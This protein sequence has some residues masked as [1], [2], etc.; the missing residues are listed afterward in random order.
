MSLLIGIDLTQFD[1]EWRS[2]TPKQQELYHK[3]STDC[4]LQ[5]YNTLALGS[6]FSRTVIKMAAVLRS[7]KMLFQHSSRAAGRSFATVSIQSFGNPAD[8][9]R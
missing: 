8:V 7:S 2:K 1:I 4:P 5:I 3:I 9:L 6:D